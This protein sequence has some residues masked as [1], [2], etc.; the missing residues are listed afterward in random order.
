MFIDIVSEVSRQTQTTAIS[1][2]M[3][4]GNW[5]KPVRDLLG[6]ACL[7]NIISSGF[8]AAS[9]TLPWSVALLPPKNLL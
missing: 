8:I 3:S 1:K 9:G 7:G 2:S 6:S 4:E 5:H